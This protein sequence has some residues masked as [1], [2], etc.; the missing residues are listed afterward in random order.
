M[1]YDVCC[2]G[3]I[4]HFMLSTLTKV[5]VQDLET[6]INI[7]ETLEIKFL[8]AKLI[9]EKISFIWSERSVCPKWLYCV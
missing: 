7:H 8:S 2:H 9:L 4:L 6:L 3:D 1:R 5:T